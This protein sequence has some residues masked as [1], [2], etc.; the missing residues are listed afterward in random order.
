V[1]ADDTAVE[2]LPHHHTLGALR[3]NS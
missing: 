1:A 2:K 3:A